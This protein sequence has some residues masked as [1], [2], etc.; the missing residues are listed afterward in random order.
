MR[1]TA[2]LIFLIF[3]GHFAAKHL[4]WNGPDTFLHR[5]DGYVREATEEQVTDYFERLYF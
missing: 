3:P 1:A 5:A 2:T 4:I